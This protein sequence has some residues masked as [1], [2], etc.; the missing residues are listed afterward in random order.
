MI[1]IAKDLSNQN[2]IVHIRKLANGAEKV[3]MNSGS[4]T[5]GHLC[6]PQR[7]FVA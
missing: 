3:R 6:D 1:A 2:E 7:K 4:L 5:K